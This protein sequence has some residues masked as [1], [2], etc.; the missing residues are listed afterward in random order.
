MGKQWR[1]WALLKT[2][3]ASSKDARRNLLNQNFKFYHP[4]Y[5]ERR[6]RGV[7]NTKPLFPYYL[8]VSVNIRQP[9]KSLC[10]TRGVSH[11]FLTGELPSQVPDHHVEYFRSIENESGY[12][13][14]P[15]YECPR[16]QPEQPVRGI[17]G[18]FEDKFGTYHGLAGNRSD[19]VKV[20]F[21]IL[22]KPT[23][24]EVDAHSLVAA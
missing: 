3:D 16:F 7:R 22:G 20:L 1:Y 12:I 4:M 2:K 18:L 6:V 21:D 11:L 19:R 5:R 8:L 9:W 24:F 13:E 14:V 10:S 23:V 15:E 17:S